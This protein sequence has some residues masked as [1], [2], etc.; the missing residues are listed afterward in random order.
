MPSIVIRPK[1]LDDLAEI[2]AHI[3]EDSPRQAD[4]FAARIHRELLLLSR[5]PY[6]GRERPELLDELRSMPVGHYVVFYVPRPPRQRP[7]GIE[8]VRVLHG[9]RDLNPFFEEEIE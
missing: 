9:S 2:W 1:A 6:I 4:T 8:V 7:R 3:A 5:Y